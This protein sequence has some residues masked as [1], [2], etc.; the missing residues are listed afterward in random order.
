MSVRI[1]VDGDDL[2][3]DLK[4]VPGASRDAIAGVIGTRLKIRTSAAPE[5]GRANEAVCRL[6]ARAMGI[7]RS[8]VCIEHGTSSPEKTVRLR[9]VD[10]ET[11]RKLCRDEPG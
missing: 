1:S 10:A 11:V 2:L 6:L 3:L 9:G 4:V 7:R 5:G 8:D